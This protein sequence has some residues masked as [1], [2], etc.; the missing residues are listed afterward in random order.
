MVE[1]QKPWLRR[2][3]L[4]VAAVVLFVG[5]LGLSVW[6]LGSP[7]PR[8]I[9]L[10]TGDPKGSFAA[11][12][13]KYKDHLKRMGLNVDLVKSSGSID[14]LHLLQ[15]GQADVAFVQA[16]VAEAVGLT[17]GLC[18]LAAIDSQPLWIFARSEVP[19]ASLR[20]L[21]RRRV[22]VGPPDSGTD[23][24]SRR[25]LEEF[26]VTKENTDFLNLSM[27]ESRKALVEGTADA[28]F[29]VCSHTAAV[30]Q[31]L[32]P[33]KQVRLVSLDSQA[34]LS[35]HF[36]YL[37]SVDLPKGAIDLARNWPSENI[38]LLAPMTLLLARENLHPQVV[39]QLLAVAQAEHAAGNLIDEPGKFPTLDGVDKPPPNIAAEKF[40]KSGGSILSRM[41][42]YWGVRLVAEAKLLVLPL[43]ALLPMWK[44]L[45]MLY[46]YR[47][48]SI[49]KRHYTAL[50]EVEGHI[51][52]CNDPV[53]L[54]KWLEALDGL[55]TDL[56][57]LS[58]KLPAHLQR[59][60]YHWRLH[61]SLVRSEGRDR[62]HRLEE[63]PAESEQRLS[64]P[65]NAVTTTRASASSAPGGNVPQ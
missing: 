13:D 17:D 56:E 47:I 54:R 64:P 29:F 30:V 21:K 57:K 28:A 33:E 49:L 55:R 62:L 59:D 26:G 45:P 32:L 23:A 1:L 65:L 41:L 24:L 58:Q 12:G 37:R 27:D 50:R 4:W 6:L 31:E 7:P 18:T 3:I 5:M 35:R 8:R 43:L 14:S 48:N 34:A 44:F 42:P 20:D 39:E 10:A 61:V 46:T 15:S 2:R 36:R 19:V 9:K 38:S 25:L 51:N 60:V 22:I 52:Q 11:L 16:G 63:K 40:L 53:E